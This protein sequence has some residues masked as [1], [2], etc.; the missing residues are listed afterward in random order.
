M[1]TLYAQ[2]KN[3]LMG[4]PDLFVLFIPHSLHFSM[5]FPS[6]SI[7][8]LYTLPPSACPSPALYV[9][10]GEETAIK[11]NNH[12]ANLISDKRQVKVQRVN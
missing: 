5:C 11:T 2:F 10:S 9:N 8:F 3:K 7:H 6:F 4:V 1:Y 12:K